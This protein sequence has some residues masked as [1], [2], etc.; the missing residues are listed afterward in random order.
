MEN[1]GLNGDIQT[2]E[3]NFHI[4]TQYLEPSEKIVSNIFEN[5]KVIIS[6]TVEV[7]DETPAQN[8]KMT[9]NGLHKEISE[10]LELLFYI[11]EKVRTIQHAVS[12]NKLGMVFL[13]KNLFD[14]A[15]GEFKRALHNDPDFTEAYN[16]L[17]YVYIKKN[18]LNEARNMFIQGIEKNANYADPHK[19]LGITYF[20]LNDFREAIQ[21]LN[22]AIE[23]NP[24]YVDA[25]FNLSLVYLKSIVDDL[26]DTTLPPKVERISH[27]KNL[28]ITIIE[29]DHNYKEQYL[30]SAL[31]FIDA[32]N[33]SDAFKAL[34]NAE[35][36]QS[37]KNEVEC[38]ENEFYLN[39]MFGGKGKDDEF[40]QDYAKRLQQA[41]EKYPEYADI[42][43]D[44][45][46]AYLIQCRNLFLK[47]L[48]EFRNALKIN[49]DY[50]RA[51]K[52]LKLAENDGK[53]FL[54]LLRAILK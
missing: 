48:E 50:K 38:F 31:E 8:I 45:G 9:V 6:K 20:L 15:I 52:N 30:N 53:G 41:T 32:K 22:K 51:E 26:Q 42:R 36:D 13:E 46:V 16:N 25:L 39:F 27:V 40:V 44:L 54:I 1:I 14:E 7:A 2:G 37:I 29:K 3:K 35:P 23:I 34:Q 12:N 19:N 24:D 28:L 21:E 17:G 49:P 18:M 5:G 11:S 4:Q 33:F 43:N 10:E 47:G